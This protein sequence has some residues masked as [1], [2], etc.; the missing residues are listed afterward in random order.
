VNGTGSYTY[1]PSGGGTS[2]LT[3]GSFY[4]IG[5]SDSGFFD[6]NNVDLAGSLAYPQA[7]PITVSLAGS[8]QK[9]FDAGLAGSVVQT[10]LITFDD[11]LLSYVIFAANVETRAIR[12]RRDLADS[13][14]VGAAACR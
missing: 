8:F 11:S 7:F 13:D 3:G 5:G 2:T 4:M 6:A 10:G 14:D 1:S 12:F 9:I